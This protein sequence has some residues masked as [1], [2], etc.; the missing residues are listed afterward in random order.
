LIELFQPKIQESLNEVGATRFYGDIA[1]AFNSLPLTNRRID[2]DLN[3]YVTERAIDGLFKLV[4]AEEQNIRQN[5]MERSTALM[6][7]V[8]GSQD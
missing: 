5:P 3:S 4:A 8:F 6:R 2:P 7:R 1:N